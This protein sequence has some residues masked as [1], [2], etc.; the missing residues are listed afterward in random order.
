MGSGGARG[1]LS[2][3]TRLRGETARRLASGLRL[4]ACRPR[5]S[6]RRGR[7]GCARF[8]Y[9]NVTLLDSPLARQ[10]RAA[11]DFYCAISNDDILKGFRRRAQRDA[12]GNDLTG[13]CSH[14]TEVIFG[15]WLS[16]MA[17]LSKAT[18]DTELADKARAL[19]TGWGETIDSERCGHYGY[20]K[21]VCGL[22]DMHVLPSRARSA[23]ALETPDRGRDQAAR[24]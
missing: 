3:P 15:Q 14:S 22:V 24:P 13:W 20:E 11:R 4:R 8:D 7:A 10:V 5:R 9:A 18:G 12:P 2:G 1:R 16:A 17:R 23:A 6:R 21:F 19:T